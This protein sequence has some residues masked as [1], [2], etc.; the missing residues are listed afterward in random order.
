M[1]EI[2]KPVAGYEGIYE[3]S[4]MGRVKSRRKIISSVDDGK[5]YLRLHLSKNGIT[6]SFRVHRLVAEAF[7]PNSDVSLKVNHIDGNKKNNRSDNLEWCT[8]A[9]NVAHAYSNGL[10]T[11]NNPRQVKAIDLNGNVQYFT[12]Q[13][14]ASRKT[15]VAQQN[16]S[17]CCKGKIKSAGGYIWQYIE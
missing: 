8:Q 3:V 12:S 14:D 9:E 5:G 16:I 13:C 17:L 6:K 1:A 2:W 4:N 7:V 10:S 15:G 11:R